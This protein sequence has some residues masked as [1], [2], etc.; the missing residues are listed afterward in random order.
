MVAKEPE[1]GIKVGI[2]GKRERKI[3][4]WNVAGINNKNKDFWNYVKE[5]D[6]ISFCET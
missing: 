2:R 1:K 5:F 6:Y 4:H 3:L